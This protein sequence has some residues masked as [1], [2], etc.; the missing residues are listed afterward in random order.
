MATFNIEELLGQDKKKEQKKTF[1]IE[2]LLGIEKPRVEEPTFTEQSPIEKPP[3]KITAEVTEEPERQFSIEELMGKKETPEQPEYREWTGLEKTI[4]PIRS[5]ESGMLKA[6]ARTARALDNTTKALSKIIN[7]VTGIPEDKLRGGLFGILE[8]DLDYYSEKARE[9]GVEGIAGEVA[10]G[11]GGASWDIP[12][13][14]TFGKWGL[15]I[16]GALYGASEGGL[17]GA[18]DGAVTGAFTHK[19][20]GVIGVLPSKARLPAF[21]GFGYAMTPGG[22][23]E[24]T[25][26]GLTWAV[27]GLAGFGKRKVTVREFMDKYPEIETRI[28]NHGAYRALKKIDPKMT[29]EE[30]KKA[31]GARKALD[32]I[33]RELW[34]EEARQIMESNKT[35]MKKLLMEDITPEEMDFLSQVDARIEAANKAGNRISMKA[36]KIPTIIDVP[37]AGKG[38]KKRRIYNTMELA[39]LE[40]DVTLKDV[41]NNADVISERLL[42]TKMT[43]SDMIKEN[44]Y[45]YR[46]L[47]DVQGR[48]L[49]PE[50]EDIKT[51]ADTRF[52]T[53]KLVEKNKQVVKQE[54]VL[55]RNEI[56]EIE[57]GKGA[58]EGKLRDM[59]SLQKD[60]EKLFSNPV[61]YFKGRVE[62]NQQEIRKIGGWKKIIDPTTK[63]VKRVSKK[64]TEAEFNLKRSLQ[65]QIRDY[66]NVIENLKLKHPTE[67][68][69]GLRPY[70]LPLPEGSELG[71]RIAKETKK[72][73]MPIF[74][75]EAGYVWLSGME[76]MKLGEMLNKY[77]KKVPIVGERLLVSKGVQ[78]KAKIVAGALK[79]FIYTI[80]EYPEIKK[81]LY[82]PMKIAE[83]RI[84]KEKE[85]AEGRTKS[86][87]LALRNAPVSEVK[88]GRMNKRPT[89]KESMERIGKWAIS[90]QVKGKEIL[91]AMGKQVEGLSRIE[92]KVYNSIRTDLENIYNQINRARG[93]M[94]IDPMPK[95]E[96][97]FTFFKN[98][99]KM[100]EDG[101]NPIFEPDSKTLHY[102]LSKVPFE[103]GKKRGKDI[104]PVDLR[105]FDV[106]KLYRTKAMKFIHKSPVI[107]KG[108]A[109]IGDFDVQER[110]TR[111][112]GSTI[113]VTVLRS[114]KN[115]R[116]NLH[117]VIN[118]WLEF[119]VGATAPTGQFGKFATRAIGSLNRNVAMWVLG[120]NFRSAFIQP[121]ALRL[122]YMEIG[123]KWLG[124]GIGG[125][126]NESKRNFC[127]RE[128]S[129]V[130]SRIFDVH[131]AE[132]YEMQMEK[133]LY[134]KWKRG[135]AG[136][137]K[138]GMKPLQIL[139]LM[140]AKVTWLGAYEKARAP[141]GKAGVRGE[142]K[143]GLGYDKAKAIIYANDTVTKTQAS[144]QPSDIAPWQRTPIGKV[145][146]LFQT[147]VINEWQYLYKDV[148]GFGERAEPMKLGRELAGMPVEKTRQTPK[149]RLWDITRLAFATMIIN[150]IYE[151][152]LGLQSPYPSPEQEM[153]TAYKEGDLDWKN[154]KLRNRIA[155][156]MAEQIP[157]FGGSI[158]WSTPYRTNVPAIPQLGIDA[159]NRVVGIIFSDKPMKP[160]QYDIDIIGKALG[161]AGGGQVMKYLRR[162]QKGMSHFES[163]IGA[164]T[165]GKK[166]VS[167]RKLFKP[168]APTESEINW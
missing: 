159:W 26:G 11:L 92:E 93:L 37:F 106:Y 70:S 97:Y 144:A 74:R 17:K 120:W 43:L 157:I 91:E 112:D 108:R 145:T 99:A 29:K 75:H 133:H 128:S 7:K 107:A 4:A 104:S 50:I 89:A 119:Q 13:I 27:L 16:H 132:I 166:K 49:R 88:L 69:V 41:L 21:A 146:S 22:V 63:K 162:R 80:E 151:G 38:L 8:K 161:L 67:I 131:A 130:L 115:L 36:E 12:T 54:S 45:L 138:V 39:A 19:M 94:G 153:W 24:R 139:D 62:V 152:V 23:E 30:I 155:K 141:V 85:V 95:V 96:N 52:L 73:E 10:E 163:Y 18:V 33:Y 31:G 55:I 47:D 168:F 122:T 5:F 76:D 71:L 113:E 156:E 82:D 126:L 57:K 142:L 6:G 135:K 20:L 118:N 2:E 102:N 48:E 98:L 58:L 109:L 64:M 117:R 44:K 158:R 77:M 61:G 32:E 3:E 100:T 83:N 66:K 147:F 78:T 87:H 40:A 114:L 124:K 103:F 136:F 42:S 9:M 137:G 164:K 160:S 127:E 129:V 25:A 110:L 134:N 167:G 125:Y 123:G 116:P 111:P 148:F 165:E 150:S 15:P 65:K 143:G 59:T 140:A 121:T 34:H 84:V 53:P 72:G 28:D 79:N 149:E 60:L 14:M 90:E 1:T 68:P 46:Y 35:T 101:F 105:I 56:A 154:R 51:I 81:M 86:W